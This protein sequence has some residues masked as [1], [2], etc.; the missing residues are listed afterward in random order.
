[1]AKSDL[2]SAFSTLPMVIEMF[3]LLGFTINE[4]YYIQVTMPMG[5]S[6]SCATYEKFSTFLEWR[7]TH[8]CTLKS[9]KHY[10]NDYIFYGKKDNPA[11]QILFDTFL[12]LCDHFGIAYSPEKFV[13]P[14]A[15]EIEFWGLLLCT[16][17][18]YVKVPLSKLDDVKSK[19]NSSLSHK[20]SKITLRELQSLIGSLNLL[21][22]AVAA[23]RACLFWHVNCPNHRIRSL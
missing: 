14:G 16:L 2:K 23:D 11:C 17:S 1:M 7:V 15:T 4:E 6:C 9:L 20:N 22:R 18:Q 3:N 5:A 21:C 8:E 13:I 19:I 12:T 10:F